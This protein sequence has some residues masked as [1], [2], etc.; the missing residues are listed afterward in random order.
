MCTIVKSGVL[1]AKYYTKSIIS[2][3]IVERERP[4]EGGFQTLLMKPE[5]I[6]TTVSFDEFL[7]GF[8][9]NSLHAVLII[10]L[11]DILPEIIIKYWIYA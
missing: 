10:K 2:M 8:I 4:L 1:S 6:H 11:L 7:S 9:V 3:A 5:K